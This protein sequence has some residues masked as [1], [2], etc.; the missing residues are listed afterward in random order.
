VLLSLRVLR[1]RESGRP[2]LRSTFVL[3]ICEEGERE[4]ERGG[5]G[6]LGCESQI[7]KSG[8]TYATQY[9]ARY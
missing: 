4:R 6:D 8:A 9:V 2:R 5:G 7:G 1:E 3:G